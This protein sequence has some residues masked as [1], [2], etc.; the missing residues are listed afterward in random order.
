MSLSLEVFNSSILSCLAENEFA[1]LSLLLWDYTIDFPLLRSFL[2]F[3]LALPSPRP[4]SRN[5][6]FLLFS[7]LLRCTAFLSDTTFGPGACR[8]SARQF[9]TAATAFPAAAGPVLA[10]R[11]LS[12]LTSVPHAKPVL[13]SRGPCSASAD[14][15]SQQKNAASRVTA[16]GR[17]QAPSRARGGRWRPPAV[18]R[19]RESP[20]PEHRRDTR[21]CCYRSECYRSQTARG[22]DVGRLAQHQ[23]RSAASP[24]TCSTCGRGV[25][26]HLALS[27]DSTLAPSWDPLLAPVA[28]APDASARRRAGGPRRGHRRRRIRRHRP[29]APSKKL[30][31]FYSS[32]VVP[33][34]P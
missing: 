16:R 1:S 13:A 12:P 23:Y 9:A 30:V 25:H 10:N 31:A 33:T 20:N 7:I 32:R 34:A 4:L 19:S 2:S 22:G 26:R 15:A 28:A 24:G 11:F 17:H 27:S 21:C 8:G 14:S 6:P 29:N 3:P 5:F 18:P